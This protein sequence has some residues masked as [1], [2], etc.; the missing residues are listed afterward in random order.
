MVEVVE[1]VDLNRGLIVEYFQFYVFSIPSMAQHQLAP[2]AE[3]GQPLVG[4][5]AAA[6]LVQYLGSVQLMYCAAP[7]CL[8]H[9]QICVCVSR[10][11]SLH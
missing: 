11:V 5:T 7:V 1:A 2:V 4:T 3:L 8:S 9:F 10:P 6:S